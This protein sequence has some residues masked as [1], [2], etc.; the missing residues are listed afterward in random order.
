[1]HLPDTVFGFQVSVFSLITSEERIDWQVPSSLYSPQGSDHTPYLP[2]HSVPKSLAGY[3]T[4]PRSPLSVRGCT[5][6]FSVL[7]PAQVM[8]LKP[9]LSPDVLLL[10]SKVLYITPSGSLLLQ[11]SF[12]TQPP[13]G[14]L[15]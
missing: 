14:L 1:M 6:V 12:V 2:S 15:R 13:S 5:H 7:D 11:H 3:P 4:T 10:S 8:P 9:S